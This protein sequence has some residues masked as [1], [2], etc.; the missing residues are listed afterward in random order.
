MALR[1]PANTKISFSCE[2]FDIE[3]S[4]MGRCSYDKF[5][6]T[7]GNTGT[8]KLC[9]N[10]LKNRALTGLPVIEQNYNLV[11]KFTSDSTGNGRGFDCKLIG[12][13]TGASIT[14]TTTTERYQPGDGYTGSKSM[15]LWI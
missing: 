10:M 13:S 5:W 11:V 3:I 14:T 7:F 6:L 1:V 8:T 9:G 2:E 12:S 15:Q 4:S